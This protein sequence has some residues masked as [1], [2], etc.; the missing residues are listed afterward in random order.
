MGV[1]IKKVVT[2]EEF[3]KIRESDYIEL[4]LTTP[5]GN[6][7]DIVKCWTQKYFDNEGL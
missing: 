3:R 6:I 5:D 1:A 2:P 4:H 7:G